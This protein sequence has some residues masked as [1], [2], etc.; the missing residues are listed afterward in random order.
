MGKSMCR[1]ILSKTSFELA[2][3]NRTKAKCLD[4][5]S[6]DASSS[7]V[8]SYFDSP[9]ALVA[10]FKPHILVLMVGYPADV[11]S[12]IFEQ[13][14]LDLLEPGSVVVDHTTS[15]PSLAVRIAQE[16]QKRECHSLDAPVSGGDVG[17]KN[18]QLSVMLGSTCQSQEGGYS[19]PPLAQPMFD[20]YSKAIT[21]AGGPG[22]GQH[23]KCA[24]Q[25]KIASTMVGVCES[26]LYAQRIG[27]A[28]FADTVLKAIMPGAAGSFSLE[29][30]GPRILNHDL[31]PGF[32]VEHFV[33]D[34]GICLDE[35]KTIGLQLPGLSMAHEL[36][37]KL[38]NM[39]VDGTAGA[40]KGTQA[41]I[42][43]LEDLN[44]N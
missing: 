29:K 42:R 6:P 44:K 16:A 21:V 9:K 12:L 22:A 7:R 18:G 13:G 26:L 41:L 5:L 35:C 1:H 3:F 2:V 19:I 8:A 17:A 31:E 27:G 28:E 24:N 10:D 32:Y 33:K 36:Y 37:K 23:T 11:E 20:C 38:E 14:L 40:R 39:D 34:L 43:V 30:L 4:L 25:I 15:S